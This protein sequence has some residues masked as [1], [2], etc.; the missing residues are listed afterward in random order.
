MSDSHTHTYERGKPRFVPALVITAVYALI[1][2]AGGWW[3]GSLALLSDA[4]HMFSDA[5]ALGL[6]A[7]AAS[8]AQRPAGHRHTYG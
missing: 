4:G 7:I 8:L 5:L 2:L 3:T 1:E 6:A